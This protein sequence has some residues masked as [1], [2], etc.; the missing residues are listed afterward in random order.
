[1]KVATG[2]NIPFLG[3]NVAAT[4]GS[5]YFNGR[6]VLKQ[7]DQ[8]IQWTRRVRQAAENR[9]CRKI[10]GYGEA[11]E[12]PLNSAVSGKLIP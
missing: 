9:L 1:M 2:R 12:L 10:D 3:G 8:K 4:Q 7:R 11:Q 6:K 5:Q